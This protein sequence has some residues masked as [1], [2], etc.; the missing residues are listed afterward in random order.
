MNRNQPFT[1]R[2]AALRS[3][4]AALVC[5]AFVGLRFLPNELERLQASWEEFAITCIPL[6]HG[7]IGI[8]IVSSNSQQLIDHAGSQRI[9]RIDLSGRS[10]AGRAVLPPEG[11]VCIT[12]D[13]AKTRL[14]AGTFDGSLIVTSL[15]GPIPRNHEKIGRVSKG[16]ANSLVCSKD[17]KVLIVKDDYSLSAWNL[18][19][20]S[21]DYGSPIWSLV[22]CTIASVVM[23]SEKTGIYCRS[24]RGTSIS[25]LIQFDIISG[26]SQPLLSK[27]G[28]R[29]KRLVI[30]PNGL[31]MACVHELGEVTL[32]SRT[33]EQAPWNDISI[34]DMC[35]NLSHVACFSSESSW[36]V[37]GEPD[38]NRLAIWD[39]A[40]RRLLFSLAEHPR[41][42]LGCDVL[43][44]QQLLS[45]SL[46]NKLRVWN[47]NDL[48]LVREIKL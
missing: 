11:A 10:R 38:S 1:Y 39:L 13:P 29:F 34:A 37:T 46:D 14:I 25:Q 5:I 30:S 3:V 22:D 47:L 7:N 23:S 28:A 8:S 18:E 36:L 35:S 6:N 16:R 12:V 41:R 44:R 33:S 4:L 42:V 20:G 45:W 21:D 48:S 24:D 17:G 15:A 9:Q 2:V 31:L 43:D 40:Q 32:L 19:V 27:N 26:Q